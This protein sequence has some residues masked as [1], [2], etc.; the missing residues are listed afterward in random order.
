MP[1]RWATSIMA[2]RDGSVSG[3][4]PEKL[5]TFIPSSTA[6]SNALAI[7]GVSAESPPTSGSGTLNTR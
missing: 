1:P 3:P 5:M 6:S 4:P 2:S 7:S